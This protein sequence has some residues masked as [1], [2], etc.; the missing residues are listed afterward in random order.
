MPFSHPEIYLTFQRF[1]SNVREFYALWA[2]HLSSFDVIMH[3]YRCNCI[4]VNEIRTFLLLDISHFGWN[5]L[6]SFVFHFEQSCGYIEGLFW[7][8]L[9]C[10]TIVLGNS[11]PLIK[12]HR[13]GLARSHDQTNK[14]RRSCH[15]CHLLFCSL[16]PTKIL[17]F[18]LDQVVFLTSLR[19]LS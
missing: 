15:Y 1:W 14:T 17:Q 18:N 13:S 16:I 11:F 3:C 12:V 5:G 4:Y 7:N 8:M 6:L 10:C 9:V 2:F 19:V